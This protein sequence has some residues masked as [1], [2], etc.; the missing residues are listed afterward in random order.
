[1]P[2]TA[3]LHTPFGFWELNPYY[4]GP[5]VPHPADALNPDHPVEVL[6]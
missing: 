2:E 6:S 5:S 4:H 1:M 3:W